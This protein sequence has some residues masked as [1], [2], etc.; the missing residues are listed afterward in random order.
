MAP[1]ALHLTEA[2]EE[3]AGSGSTD[4]T[5]RQIRGSS[6]LLIGNVISLSITFLPHI[7][8]VRYLTMEAYGHLTYALSLIAVC[9]TYS[10]GFN[11]AMSRFVPI[12]HAKHEPSKLLGSIVVVFAITLGIS[13]LFVAAFG[14]AARQILSLLTHGREPAGLLLILIFLVPLETLEILIMNLFACFARAKTIFWGRYILSPGLRVIVISLVVLKH[15]GLPFLAAG[16]VLCQVAILLPFGVLLMRELGRQNLLRAWGRLILPVREIFGFSAPLMASNVVG[17]VGNSMPV[18]LLGYFHPMSTVA[19]YRVVLPAAVL[20]NMILGNFMP[21]YMPSASRLFAEGDLRRLNHHFWQTAVWMGLLEFP[22]FAL[23]SCFARPV[24]IL[25]YGQR[26]AS[27]APIL[28]ILSLGYFV[29]AIFGFNSVTLKVMGKIR[30]MVILNI[31]TPIVMVV[32]NLLL[33]PRFGALGAAIAT[34]AGVI[35]QCLFRQAGL[36]LGCGID[37]FAMRYARFF[38]ML[39]CSALGLYCIQAVTPSNVYFAVLMASAA[40]VLVL[41]LVKKQL[42]IADTFP[43]VLRLPLLGRLLA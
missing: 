32:L 12:Y 28:A 29:N 1:E 14:V 9:K 17:L 15:Y 10:L 38:L 43:E 7:L 5:R 39:C 11:E 23:T 24:T 21:L 31:V 18:L 34:S 40:S 37:F 25:L 4:V 27:S 35:L 26:Y 8:L 22:I 6:L 30:L 41:W 3:Q 2:S 42:R 16:Y 13:G 19:F 36:W 33:I 20:S